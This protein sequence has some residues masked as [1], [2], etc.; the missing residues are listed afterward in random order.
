MSLLF[1]VGSDLA[2]W[3]DGRYW[4]ALLNVIAILVFLGNTVYSVL[5]NI[6]PQPEN[7]K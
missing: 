2:G 1:R 5:I 6:R 7:L 4:G 3:L